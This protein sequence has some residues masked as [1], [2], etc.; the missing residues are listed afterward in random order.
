MDQSSCDPQKL[1]DFLKSEPQ[2]AA[3]WATVQGITVEQI[4]RFVRSLTP[5]V[6]R[7]DT[8]VTNHGY[9]NGRATPI[10][11]VLEAGTAVLVD[12]LGQPRVKCYCGNPLAPPLP[13]TQGVRYT[14]DPWPGFQQTNIITIVNTT[15]IRIT[16]FVLVD[17]E[18]PGH[19]TRPPGVPEEGPPPDGEIMTDDLCDL[20]PEDCPDPDEP[21]LGTGDVQV[22]LRWYSP[23]DLDL[24]V[25]DPRGESINF[26]EPRSRSGGQL[27][28]DSNGNCATKT[29]N[30]V[31]NVFW[32]TGKSPDGTY[33]VTVSYYAECPGGTGPQSFELTVLVGGQEIPVDLQTM[34]ADGEMEAT[35]ELLVV[36]SQ[37]Q[38]IL[39]ATGTLTPGKR[40]AGAFEKTPLPEE[41]PVEEP[42]VEEPPVEEPP[43]GEEPAEPQMT[44]EEYCRQQYPEAGPDWVL[45]P[46]NMGYTLCM[47][48]PTT[49]D[50][51]DSPI[52]ES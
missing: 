9:Y 16:N 33:T 44:L 10:Q 4:P 46:E 26:S 36:N 35:I 2:K 20:F 51:T 39:G 21:V 24:A 12:D 41:P 23:A 3:A 37:P 11:S 52:T 28:V 25:T 8:R 30:P 38:M 50:A 17:L 42:P 40:V 19:F 49:N 43:P 29:S 7:A 22:T 48:D 15:N 14:G 13:Q 6:L 5:V 31:E 18:K 34:S 32:P 1:I 45:G 47:H 27:D